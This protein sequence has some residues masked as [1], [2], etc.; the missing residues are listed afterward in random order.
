MVFQAAVFLIFLLAHLGRQLIGRQSLT[1][2]DLG[3]LLIKAGEPA[4]FGITVELLM[5]ASGAAIVGGLFIGTQSAGDNSAKVGT[6][7]GA[8]VLEL[9]STVPFL[10]L[11]RP[12]NSDKTGSL[13]PGRLRRTD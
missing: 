3:L 5:L 8:L 4:A 13:L 1:I 6:W 12:F 11:V 10:R 2:E 7:S 9:L